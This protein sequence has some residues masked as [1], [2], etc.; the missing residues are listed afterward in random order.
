MFII[1]LTYT[2]PIEEV[3]RHLADHRLWVKA[4]FDD[5]VFV[6]SG[7]QR[8][9]VGGA[10]IAIGNDRA[11]IEAVKVNGA[12][13]STQAGPLPD[14][15]VPQR[16]ILEKRR[17]Q[18][19]LHDSAVRLILRTVELRTCRRRRRRC[20]PRHRAQLA[21]AVAQSRAAALTRP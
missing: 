1:L 2:K 14:S 4:G 17:S 5:G 20:C 11:A 8:P 21:E 7:G 3:D 18:M 9:R 6:L 19:S 16:I 13:Q 10:L 15:P 12:R